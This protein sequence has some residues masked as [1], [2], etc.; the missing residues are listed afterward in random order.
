ML[1]KVLM[2]DQCRCCAVSRGKSGRGVAKEKERP[3]G[4]EFSGP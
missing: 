3:T 4:R 1:D 2:P